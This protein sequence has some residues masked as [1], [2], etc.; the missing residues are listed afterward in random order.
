MIQ[1]LE[2]FNSCAP[3]SDSERKLTVV[4]VDDSLQ[5]YDDTAD[6]RQHSCSAVW[7]PTVLI[8]LKHMPY[9]MSYAIPTA[10][11]QWTWK[12]MWLITFGQKPTVP[13]LVHFGSV[14]ALRWGVKYTG[15]VLFIFVL[16][17]WHAQ[18]PNARTRW[19]QSGSKEVDLRTVG[20]LGSYSL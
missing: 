17:V 5:W 3:C 15:E 1:M 16:L 12:W 13:S 4:S 8:V 14:V 7:K 20:P 18:R 19:V 11:K 10:F 6:H 9:A 2:V